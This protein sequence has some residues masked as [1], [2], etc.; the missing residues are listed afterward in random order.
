M[1]IDVE[2]KNQQNQ[3]QIKHEEIIPCPVAAVY[4]GEQLPGTLKGDLCYDTKL[5]QACRLSCHCSGGCVQR[6]P[7]WLSALSKS[8]SLARIGTWG[9]QLSAENC[10]TELC[11]SWS[12]MV[13][14]GE[15]CALLPGGSNKDV[16][17]LLSGTCRGVMGGQ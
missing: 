7:G 16:G 8:L 11:P 6:T 12:V 17:N 10:P 15:P 4:L 13:G 1:G 14:P 3:L 5:C 9:K 2:S